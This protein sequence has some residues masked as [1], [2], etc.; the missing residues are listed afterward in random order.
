MKNLIFGVTLLALV[1]IATGGCKKDFQEQSSLHHP[2]I[3]QN[4]AHKEA[5]SQMILGDQ[6]PN[7]YLI[8]S[9]TASQDSLYDNGFIDAKMDLT[10][11]HNYVRFSI[12]S[13]T[14]YDQM[15]SDSTILLFDHP[16]DYEIIQ[17]GDWYHD[18]TLPDSGFTY[19]YAVIPM[20]KSIPA[21]SHT[22]LAQVLFDEDESLDPVFDLI[23]E[24]SFKLLGI[25]DA[26][27]F[28]EGTGK[29]QGSRY[30][31]KG[32]VE[33][34]DSDLGYKH[35]MKGVK[36][37][38]RRW[39]K[40]AYALTNSTG[41]FWVARRYR[42]KVRYK[43]KW[44]R[45]HFTI[46]QGNWA[47]AYTS[48]PYQ[49]SDW[50]KLINGSGTM[51]YM[52]ANIHNGAYEMYYGNRQGLKRPPGSSGN[53]MKIGAYG[54]PAGTSL[55]DHAHWRTYLT[56]PRLRIYDKNRNP[57][58]LFATTTH[59][60]GHALHWSLGGNFNT[61]ETLLKESFAEAV[62]WK[63]VLERYGTTIAQSEKINRV[64]DVLTDQEFS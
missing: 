49:K 19:Y 63:F 33:F 50:N 31:P 54:N 57:A 18:P 7:P 52:Y 41:N 60:I 35:G 25:W 20:N 48:G 3:E 62:A 27:D 11:S 32:K 45:N 37:Y 44:E 40:T 1:G 55:G 4:S 42:G 21:V 13:E 51:T 10:A 16:L 53:K 34:Y 28:S 15:E 30:N 46:R 58:G 17:D 14:E 5:S 38:V 8:S 2:E 22:I 56:W 43:I 39:F 61:V 36:I 47:Q 29:I 24:G 9:L 26:N 6:L 12:Q 23:E 64:G 59:E